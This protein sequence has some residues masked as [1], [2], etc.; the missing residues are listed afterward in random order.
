MRF[1]LRLLAT[2]IYNLRPIYYYK[3]WNVELME[4]VEPQGLELKHSLTMATQV[5]S[6]RSQEPIWAIETN[7]KP[8]RNIDQQSRSTSIADEAKAITSAMSR[9]GLLAR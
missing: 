6:V 7:S 1:V 4:Y 9:D 5:S 8:T 2:S 3:V